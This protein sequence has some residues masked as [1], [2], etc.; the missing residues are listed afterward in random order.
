MSPE[1][2]TRN[3]TIHAAYLSFDNLEEL[4]DAT[5]GWEF[6]WRQLDRGPL[7]ASLLQA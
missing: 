5:S 6:D 4:A 3:A 7:K 1:T 2:S